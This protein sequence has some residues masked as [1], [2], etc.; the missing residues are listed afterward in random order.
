MLCQMFWDIYF[1]LQVWRCKVKQSFASCA[2]S[3]ETNESL[4]C[5]L[6]HKPTQPQTIFGF[7]IN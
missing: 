4:V 2:T 5:H 7:R 3:G 1:I 6:L